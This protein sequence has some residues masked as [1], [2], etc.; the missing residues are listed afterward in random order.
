MYQFLLD[1]TEEVQT[2]LKWNEC[3]QAAEA[4]QIQVL[5]KKLDKANSI[6]SEIDVI[7]KKSAFMTQEEISQEK[8]IVKSKLQKPAEIIRDIALLKADPGYLTEDQIENLK[9]YWH[10]ASHN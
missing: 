10:I 3:Q 1:L 9:V 8:E 6:Q 4:I 5:S 7:S 2:F